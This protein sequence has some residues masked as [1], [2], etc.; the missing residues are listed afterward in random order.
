MTLRTLK[1]HLVHC[2]KVEEDITTY[3]NEYGVN[4]RSVLLE[5]QYADLCSGLLLPDVMHDLYEGVLQYEAKLFINHAISNH[6]F[7]AKF[8]AEKMEFMEAGDRPTIVTSQVLRCDDRSLG[9]KGEALP[10]TPSPSLHPPS[11]P[12]SSF[13]SLLPS[14][15]SLPSTSLP[16]SHSLDILARGC[17]MCTCTYPV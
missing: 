16:H 6:Y 11:L 8:L 7:T 13:P 4:H 2:D 17:A 9:Q 10:P 3:L 12:L 15:P 14:S 5:L 1:N